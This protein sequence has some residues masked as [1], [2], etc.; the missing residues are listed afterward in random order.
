MMSNGVVGSISIAVASSFGLSGLFASS[1]HF[2]AYAA[3]CGLLPSCDWI[4]SMISS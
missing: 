2:N 3:N 1:I 4:E